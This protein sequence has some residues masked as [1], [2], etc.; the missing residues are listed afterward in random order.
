MKFS[1]LTSKLAV[2]AVL[3]T[4]GASNLAIA[5][6]A[7]APVA[8]AKRGRKAKGGL[9]A[10]A[11]TK[12]ETALGKPLTADQK[13]QLDTAANTRRAATKAA[14]DAYDNEVARVTGMTLEKVRASNKKAKPAA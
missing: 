6:P 9:T 12:I 11:Q 3:A 14:N 1:S 4:M 13:A 2:A 5:Q 10:K 7:A 8:K